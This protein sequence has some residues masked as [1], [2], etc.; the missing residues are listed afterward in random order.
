MDGSVV[1]TKDVEVEIW[2]D[3]IG[4]D[5]LLEELMTRGFSGSVDVLEHWLQSF[6]VPADLIAPIKA[7]FDQPLADQ[8]AWY[9]WLEFANA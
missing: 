8:R 2:M 5:D 1:I 3:E 6:N 9:R 7:H 4:T